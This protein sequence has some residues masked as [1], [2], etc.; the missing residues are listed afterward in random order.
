MPRQPR[1][2]ARNAGR[3]PALPAWP[4]AGDYVKIVRW[5]R[6]CAYRPCRNA[7]RPRLAARNAGRR[8]ALPAWP[9]AG[10]Y[11]KIVRWP[12][13]CA[14]RRCRNARRPRLAARNAGRRPALPAWPTAGDYVKIVRWPRRCAYRR[15][16]NAPAAAPRG[17]ECGPAARAP[18]VADR[19]RLRED[20]SLAASVR[21]PAMPEC[22]AAA[23]RGAECGP[24]ARAPSVADRRRLREDR[25][26]AAS[27]RLPAM[28]ECPGSRASRRGMR[29]SGPRSPR[30]EPSRRLDRRY[31]ALRI[32]ERTQQRE[33]APEV[34][35]ERRQIGF[36]DA[37][38]TVVQVADP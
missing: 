23:P 18:R 12:R 16:R 17:A 14:Y 4:T 15:C 19:R 34:L 3:R 10:D 37:V 2:A 8:P 20:R 24:T 30:G 11:V 32:R 5:P 29:A 27:V 35:D 38:E 33:I 13:R 21:L 22:P 9:T 6:R 26:L 28:P 25:S 36:E 7:R 31:C 1:L